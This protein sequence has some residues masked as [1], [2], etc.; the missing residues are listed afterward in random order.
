MDGQNV[1]KA[2]VLVVGAG[3]AGCAAALRLAED[4]SVD[5]FWT[6]QGVIQERDLSGVITPATAITTGQPAVYNKG[7]SVFHRLH[8]PITGGLQA[9]THTNNSNGTLTSNVTYFHEMGSFFI[10]YMHFSSEASVWGAAHVK[11]GMP[12]F[13]AFDVIGTACVVQSYS[14][15]GHIRGFGAN[16]KDIDYN[17]QNL[18]N[19]RVLVLKNQEYLSEKE[20]RICLGIS[21]V[22][23][24]KLS[25]A[26]Q[27]QL[28]TDLLFEA[29]NVKVTYSP[30]KGYV[31]F[32]QG[33]VG[34]E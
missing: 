1:I 18:Y 27:P 34:E 32:K 17:E 11:Y 31:G 4:K 6:Y 5:Q 30:G 3:I 23:F 7:D 2:D 21:P 22:Y 20:R 24:V 9:E 14:V 16:D 25:N 28:S 33:V 26:G 13:T 15:T 29:S 8:I 10:S 12:Y 19:F